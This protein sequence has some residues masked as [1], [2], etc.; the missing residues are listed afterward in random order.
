MDITKFWYDQK[1]LADRR[2]ADRPTD[3]VSD[4]IGQLDRF[5]AMR[6]NQ[7]GKFISKHFRRD[8]V[9]PAAVIAGRFR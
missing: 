2:A 4:L 7:S 3:R 9:K 8:Q 6:R 1:I 5:A